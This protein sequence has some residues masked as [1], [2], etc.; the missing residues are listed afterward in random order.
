MNF[1]FPSYNSLLLLFP[2]L[3]LFSSF[4]FQFI[5]LH[6]I[7]IFHPLSVH[8]KTHLLLVLDVPGGSIQGVVATTGDLALI[9]W[10]TVLL[11]HFP[12][13]ILDSY[14]EDQMRFCQRGNIVDI[15]AISVR[16]KYP[17]YLRFAF[18]IGGSSG[19]LVTLANQSKLDFRRTSAL[20]APHAVTLRSS[21]AAIL[22]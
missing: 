15:G 22:S 17:R 1:Y 4:F 18:N 20:K 9:F 19:C 8:F 11:Q 14:L 6:S 13:F 21:A 3:F 16:I 12:L 7:Q 5:L 10:V 2:L